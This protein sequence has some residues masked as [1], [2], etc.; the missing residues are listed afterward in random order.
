M[1]FATAGESDSSE[2]E[3]EKTYKYIN[4]LSSGVQAETDFVIGFNCFIL[5]AENLNYFE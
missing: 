5:S 3:F 2:Y 1:I 4:I